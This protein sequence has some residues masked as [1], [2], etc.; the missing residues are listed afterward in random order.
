MPEIRE[1]L[2][3][4]IVTL[5]ISGRPVGTAFVIRHIEDD[6]ISK[7]YYLITCQHCVTKEV[8]ARFASGFS[9]IVHSSEWRT[10]THKDDVAALDVTDVVANDGEIGSLDYGI[11]QRHAEPFFGVGVDLYMLGL[12][13][14]E[15]DVGTNLPRARFGNLSAVADER[16]LH[17]Q[18]NGQERPCH[19]G[20]M[21]SRTGFSG[22]PVIGYLAL[23]ALGHV[24]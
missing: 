17:R 7:S 4:S 10:S 21:R 9:L 20:D 14:D 11:A 24:N 18:G 13:V 2:I 22:S 23:P 15:K 8:V 6:M 5:H 1:E 12:L 19:L 3:R 16:V